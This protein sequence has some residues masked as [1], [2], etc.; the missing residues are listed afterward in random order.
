MNMIIKRDGTKEK[1]DA[2]KI[3]NAVY[4]STINSKYGVDKELGKKISNNIQEMILSNSDK[5][6]TVEDIQDTVEL[7]HIE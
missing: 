6:F 7:L 2:K 4:K 1:F 3:E 5:S